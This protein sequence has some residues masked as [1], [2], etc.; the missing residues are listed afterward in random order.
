MCE[1]SLL[2][3]LSLENEYGCVN[4]KY[5]MEIDLRENFT[6]IRSKAKFEQMV[7]GSCDV[8]I[9]FTKY[10]LLVGKKGFTN[11]NSRIEYTLLKR[12]DYKNLELTVTFF[13]NITTVAPNLT[14]HGLIE[15]LDP[16]EEIEIVIVE[17]FE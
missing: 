6:I 10:D 12:C 13:Q 15:K 5:Q 11:G 9:D 14:Y 8:M 7:S 1:D 16:E 2:D 3:V 17:T 4:T